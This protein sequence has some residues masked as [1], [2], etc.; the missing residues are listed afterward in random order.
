MLR[1]VAS[2]LATLALTQALLAEPRHNPPGPLIPWAKPQYFSDFQ[3]ERF[4]FPR[5]ETVVQGEAMKKGEEGEAVLRLQKALLDLGFALPAGADSKYGGQT[6]AAVKAFQSFR[7]LDMTGVVDRLTIN[8]LDQVSPQ[9][10]K[11]VW[12]DASSASQA[13]SPAPEIGNKKVRAVVDLSEHRLV[14]YSDFGDVERVF[15]VAVGATETPTD[16]GTKIVHD[17]I[18]DPTDLAK[19]LWPESKGNAFG[20][21]LIDLNWY[22]PKDKSTRA[23]DEELHGTFV[24]NSLGQDAS[25][26]CVRINNDNIE[27]LYQ[28]LQLGDLVVIRE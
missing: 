25:H 13:V 11:R 23:S 5:F 17:K 24:L 6:V 22:D 3:N 12:E 19:K 21:R 15:P 9:P 20:T 28:N 26:G 7:G 18:D 16:V 14:V 8:A 1:P 2:L 10:G 27:W 4:N